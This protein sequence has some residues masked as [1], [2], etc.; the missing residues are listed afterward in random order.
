MIKVAKINFSNLSIPSIL[1][2]AILV[3][4]SYLFI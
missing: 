4:G 3:Q 1:I 2:I